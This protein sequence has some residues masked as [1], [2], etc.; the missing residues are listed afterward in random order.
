VKCSWVI[1]MVSNLVVVLWLGDGKICYTSLLLN[2]EL[3]FSL[4]PDRRSFSFKPALHI[5][6][7][8]PANERAV[9]FNL[10]L[11]FLYKCKIE[12]VAIK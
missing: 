7:T 9:A 1:I 10:Q 2:R 8:V 6:S 3:S 4:L 12:N 11:T 5:S